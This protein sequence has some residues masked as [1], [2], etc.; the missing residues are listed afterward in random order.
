MPSGPLIA[1]EL[2][3]PL[4]VRLQVQ[5]HAGDAPPVELLLQARQHAAE[6]A[7]DGLVGRVALVGRH[8]V[9]QGV[10]VHVA[11]PWPPPGVAGCG[12]P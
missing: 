6:I 8:E 10:L 5:E 4:Q 1:A 12:S 2:A 3:A 7:E 11:R 9:G